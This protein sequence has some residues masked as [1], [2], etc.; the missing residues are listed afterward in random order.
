MLQAEIYL[1]FGPDAVLLDSSGV[2]HLQCGFVQM[3]LISVFV[4]Q[5]YLLPHTLAF[6]AGLDQ[7]ES[8]LE[9]EPEVLFALIA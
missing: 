1:F 7:I 3:S 9:N 8:C 5:T 6:H 4:P 2:S